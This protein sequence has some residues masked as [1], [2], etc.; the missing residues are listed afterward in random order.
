MAQQ[1]TAED[2]RQS[3]N[4]HVAAKGEEIY[5]KYGPQIGWNELLQLL[6]DR[7]AVR[8]PCEVVFDPGPLLEGEFAC[9]LP[10]GSHPED[11]FKI[12][13]HPF[14]A[15]DPPRVAYLV[16]YQ[17]VL[18]NYGEFASADDAET[19]GSAA[20]GLSKDEYYQ[21]LCAMAD[22]IGASAAC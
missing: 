11:G 10:K 16:L 19:F 6:A 7:S 2:F 3:L 22:Q 8:Y 1:L 18:V 17:L 20:L 13:V 9:A 5:L 12:H 21:A 15:T 4:G 14:F